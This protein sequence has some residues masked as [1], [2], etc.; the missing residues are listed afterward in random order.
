[1][2]FHRGAKGRAEEPSRGNTSIDLAVFPAGNPDPG[3]RGCRRRAKMKKRINDGNAQRGS[4]PLFIL[5]RIW[6]KDSPPGD[7]RRC[8][9]EE[10][11]EKSRTQSV[12]TKMANIGVE[13]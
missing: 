9:K 8:R 3:I 7:F 6:H 5:S 1:M 13:F 12:G 4:F 2:L 11:I 10:K